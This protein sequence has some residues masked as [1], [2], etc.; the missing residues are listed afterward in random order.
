[1]LAQT[2]DN[3]YSYEW[4]NRGAWLEANTIGTQVFISHASFLCSR[5]VFKMLMLTF[6][7]HA[8]HLG[9]SCYY[10]LSQLSNSQRG[11]TQMRGWGMLQ[12]WR[13]RS[14]PWPS[15]DSTGSSSC[16]TPEVMACFLTF[17]ATVFL[18]HAFVLS[19]IFTGLPQFQITRLEQVLQAVVQLISGFANINHISQYMQEVLHWLSFPQ[20]ILYT[21]F[22]SLNCLP[23]ESKCS[24]GNN[25]WEFYRLLIVYV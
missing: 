24:I 20:R 13:S 25:W 22:L 16:S 10:Q 5:L 6:A 17:K 21:L 8:D 2:I 23:L 19:R 12:L 15:A 11:W 14:K 3:T 7:P 1:M 18:V 9:C 4:P